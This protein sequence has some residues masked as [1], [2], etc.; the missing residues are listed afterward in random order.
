M[1]LSVLHELGTMYGAFGQSINKQ[2]SGT[3]ICPIYTPLL[4]IC[5]YT[6][7]QEIKCYFLPDIKIIMLHVQ[8]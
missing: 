3:P 7:T 6:A 2:V 1:S 8:P 5:L 4:M